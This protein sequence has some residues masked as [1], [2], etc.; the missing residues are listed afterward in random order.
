MAFDIVVRD[1]IASS[2]A[3]SLRG[4]EVRA[5]AAT[6]SLGRMRASLGGLRASTGLSATNR[7]FTTLSGN[8]AR[9]NRQITTLNQGFVRATNSSRRL[10]SGLLLLQGAESLVEALDSYQT[11]QNRLLDTTRVNSSDGTEDT[12]RSQERL[13]EVS[14]KLFEVADAARVPVSSLAKTYRRFDAALK[15]VGAGQE[16]TLRVTE[17]V[18]KLLSLSGAN[19]GEAASA[20]LQLS[21]AFNKGKLDG[22]EFRSV[23]ELMPQAIDAIVKRLGIAR[24]QIFEYSKDGRISIDILRGAF[25][26]LAVSADESFKRLPRTIGNA[27]TSLTNVITEAFGS[28]SN[29][30]SF[31]SSIIAGIDWIKNN[32]P[33]VINLMK[34]FVV[35][36]TAQTVGGY[37]VNLIGELGSLSG[38]LN[39]LLQGFVALTAYFVFFADKIK[40]TADGVTT[41]QDVFVGLYQII[42]DTLSDNSLFGDLFSAQGAQ[43]AFSTIMIYGRAVVAV[44]LTVA[45]GIQ[46]IY[47]TWMKLSWGD[48]GKLVIEAFTTITGFISNALLTFAQGLAIVGGKARDALRDLLIDFVQMIGQAVNSVAHIFPKWLVSDEATSGLRDM[49]VSLE[50]MKKTTS[51]FGVTAGLEALKVDLLDSTVLL[52]EVFSLGEKLRDPFGGD[53]GFTTQGGLLKQSFDQNQ[54]D[55][56][57]SWESGMDAILGVAKQNADKRIAEEKRVQKALIPN[58]GALRKGTTGIPIQSKTRVPLSKEV[59]AARKAAEKAAAGLSPRASTTRASTGR[60]STTASKDQVTK[61]IES[62]VSRKGLVGA[63]AALDGFNLSLSNTNSTPDSIILRSPRMQAYGKDLTTTT[64]SLDNTTLAARR[65]GDVLDTITFAHVSA[66]ATSFGIVA[67]DVLTRVGAKAATTGQIITLTQTSAWAAASKA[68]DDYASNAIAKMNA[69]GVASAGSRATAGGVTGP[70]THAVL[71]K[72]RVFL[73]DPELGD[74]LQAATQATVD[75]TKSQELS[76]VKNTSCLPVRPHRTAQHWKR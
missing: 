28:S 72:V 59:T 60:A 42:R 55:W 43:K 32:L 45:A 13:L 75:A 56:V 4:I 67:I 10:L 66:S 30:N 37:F 40:V 62:L 22:D 50:A 25:A 18:G 70:S 16:E 15:G 1:R 17:T 29:A 46:S 64:L 2:I 53:T 47:D 48:V 7:S 73:S 24:S 20:M 57:S 41:L 33:T 14:R 8:V 69:V 34:T 36:M 51:D 52:R 74:Y 61:I 76:T 58:L 65:L 71:R 3:S 9:T 63:R 39:L 68:V 31:T 19:A 6:V 38:W 5:N 26:D 54:K 49:L 35:I 27:L 21:Q 23:A 12:I 11:L 44:L